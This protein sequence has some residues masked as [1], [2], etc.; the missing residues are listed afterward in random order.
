MDL[1]PPQKKAPPVTLL[2]ESK[3]TKQVQLD[4]N[5]LAKVTYI[6]ANLD[7]KQELTLTNFLQ[8][9][10]DIFAWKVSDVP[11]VPRELVEKQ[12]NRDKNGNFH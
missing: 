6:G 11:G 3:L 9:N 12:I 2:V 1:E 5:N 10:R 8:E 4:Q 7:S